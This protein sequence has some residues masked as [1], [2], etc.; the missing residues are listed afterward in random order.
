MDKLAKLPDYD[1]QIPY[2]PGP[3]YCC[4]KQEERLELYQNPGEENTDIKFWLCQ[5]CFKELNET[6]I[7]RRGGKCSRKGIDK[8]H[9]YPDYLKKRGANYCERCGT[10]DKLQAYPNYFQ[11]GG[12]P[13]IVRFCSKCITEFLYRN[14]GYPVTCKSCGAKRS[15]QPKS[16]RCT[17]PK[18]GARDEHL[19]DCLI[20]LNEIRKDNSLWHT[21]F[22]RNNQ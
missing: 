16:G 7:V 22:K 10:K 15:F 19:Y 5:D 6:D 2:G 12:G 4:G 20:L 13:K 9:I 1:E 3:C 8:P 18:C 14:Y 11:D 17:C 21:L